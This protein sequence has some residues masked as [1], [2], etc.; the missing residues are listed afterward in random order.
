MAAFVIVDQLGI[1]D[2]DTMKEYSKGVGAT[3]AK[4][5][6]EAIARD[7][8]CEVLEGTYQ[9][10]RIIILKFPDMQALKGWYDSEDY[11]ELKAMRH[12]SSTANMY[13]VDGF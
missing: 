8:G 2:P 5:G 9:P 10:R 1:T 4:F 11:A 3:V 12:R 13:A 7:D 6:G